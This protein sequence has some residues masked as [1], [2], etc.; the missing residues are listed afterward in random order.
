MK[1]RQTLLCGRGP[2]PPGHHSPSSVLPRRSH[3]LHLAGVNVKR[4]I[5]TPPPPPPLWH[6]V[7]NRV[8]PTWWLRS[9]LPHAFY[10]P[11]RRPPSG[12]GANP[13]TRAALLN[14]PF[15]REPE[16]GLGHRTTMSFS[17]LA[18]LLS[19]CVNARADDFFNHA[20]LS[21]G[22]ATRVRRNKKE[23]SRAGRL[24]NGKDAASGATLVGSSTQTSP[25]PL[26]R[27]RRRTRK[28]RPWT[29]VCTLPLA[30][31]PHYPKE[32][33]FNIRLLGLYV[34]VFIDNCIK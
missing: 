17:F 15:R 19:V 6:P 11:S 2:F 18:C 1:T 13:K 7:R 33:F 10:S 32:W 9:A 34:V 30:I 3:H 24:R 23:S 14:L 22:E 20:D 8:T 21:P 28:S 29:R 4:I 27:S 26:K 5:F 16:V 12:R 31:P 25:E